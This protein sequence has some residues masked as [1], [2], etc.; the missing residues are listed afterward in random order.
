MGTGGGGAT[1]LSYVYTYPISQWTHLAFVREGTG[2][3]QTKLYIN[4]TLVASGTAATNV[5]TFTGRIGGIEWASGFNFNGHI[6]NLRLVV[7][8]AVYTSNFTP[9]TSALTA[10]ANTL[11]LT[12][13]S[14]RFVDNSTNNYAITRAGDVSVQAFSPFAPTAS[15]AAA[16][17]GGSGYF[18]G[19]GDYLVSSSNTALQQGTGDY[20]Y[21][22]W[23]YHTNT[24]G[25]QTYF[26]RSTAGNYNGVYF[27]KDTS[28]NVGVYYTTQIATGNVTIV[29]G[30]WYHLAAARSSGRLRLFVNGVLAA[31]V[32]DTTNLTESVVVIGADANGSSPFNGY[33]SG[34]RVLKS[35]GLYT[36][37]FTPPTAPLTNVANTSLLCNFTNAGITDATAKSVLETVG[38]AKV[39]TAIKQFGS[40]SI[41]LY[42][43]NNTDYLYVK[44]SS[45][46]DL[47]SGDFTVEFWMYPQTLSTSF[48]QDTYSC[49]MDADS[50]A[51]TGTAWWVV[52]QY[53]QTIYWAT[54]SGTYAG[55]TGNIIT[56]ANTWY[57]VAISRASGVIRTFVNGAQANTVSYSTAIGAQNRNLYI[58]K[59]PTTSRYFKGY[60]DDIRITKGIARYTQNF[61]LP[62]TEFLTK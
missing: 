30:Q 9:P 37:A 11:L 23:V 16:N 58:G 21:E 56:A 46:A 14:N 57:H 39:N 52:H 29:S 42:T 18:D 1:I 44:S 34:A 17:V 32:A 35:N 24:S 53:N 50:A 12:C 51:G 8:S 49:I 15:Y 26:A 28:N 13:Q 54:D 3:N 60:L 31:N 33:I 61:I 36:A 27:Y 55:Q 62:T 5:P 20:T 38:A 59:Q 4:G 25:Q 40:G 48:A 2:S 43:N 19:S 22:C 10:I 6:S 47:G 45:A 41:D 7:G